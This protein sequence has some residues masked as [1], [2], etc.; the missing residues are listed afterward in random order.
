[1]EQIN[2]DFN[3]PFYIVEELIDYVELSAE[4]LFKIYEMGKYKKFIRFSQ[5]K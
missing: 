2:K 5:N 4:R 1:M 3:V